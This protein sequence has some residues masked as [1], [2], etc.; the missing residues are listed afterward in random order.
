MK[1]M[2]ESLQRMRDLVRTAADR[3][4]NA[5]N[6]PLT[7]DARPIDIRQAIVEAI[8]SRV[9]PVGGGR[10]VLPD[11]YVKVRVLTTDAAEE[12]ALQTALSD[13]QAI[14]ARR[15]RELACDVDP[16]FRVDVAYVRKR[17]SSWAEGQPM[18]IEF[19][20]AA[21]SAA[22]ASQPALVLTIVNGRASAESYVLREPI[23]RVGRSVSPVD[24]L[25]RPRHNHV[26]FL[27]EG[28]PV[29]ATVGR[30]HCEIR[31]Q[32]DTGQYRIFDERSAN[33]T[34]IVRNGEIIAV[35]AQDPFGV[36]IEAGDE[37]QF[38]SAS[39]RVELDSHLPL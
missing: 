27:E 39:A 2:K 35:P 17:P 11:R 22:P 36:A 23:V 12:R 34:R 4:G 38:G 32:A 21:P 14:A 6:P 31:Y 1:E 33:G 18:Q 20:A 26:A 24:Q 30:G 29:S 10:R 15:L 28:D 7:E 9:Q 13:V 19:E 16:A 8:E 25:G 5:I 3:V 37:L